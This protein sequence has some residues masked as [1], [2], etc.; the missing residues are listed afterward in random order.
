MM[1]AWCALG[2]CSAV[3]RLIQLSRELVTG[4]WSELRR[5]RVGYL[6]ATVAVAAAVGALLPYDEAWVELLS[7]DRSELMLATARTFS[8]WGD[9]GGTLV[10]ALALGGAGFVWRR[11]RLRR[12]AWA[13]VLA[14]SMA[15][16][17]ANLLRFSVG[18]PRPNSPRP[19]G[20]YGPSVEYRMLSFPSAHAA[21]A[22]ATAS[23]LIVPLPYLGWPAA[24]LA[25]GVMWSRMHRRRHHPSDVLV[26]AFL[27]VIAGLGLGRAAGGAYRRHRVSSVE[28]SMSSRC[29]D[30][31]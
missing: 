10:V 2:R 12:I 11:P 22:V 4:W 26:G 14:A 30:G 29:D 20:V 27:G 15:G 31:A 25:G 6:L 3:L 8:Q 28:N 1:R 5:N 18:R 23:T 9:L 16:I 7:T 24:A 19:D 13:V 17:G 21:T